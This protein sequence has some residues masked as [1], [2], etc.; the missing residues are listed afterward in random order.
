MVSQTHIAIAQD[1]QASHSMTWR[2]NLGRTNISLG[3]PRQSQWWT[4]LEPSSCPG[5]INGALTSLP[6][7][8]LDK[9]TRNQV[10]DYFNNTW[11]LT[12]VL[13]SSLIG[14]EAFYRPP[15]HSLRHPLVF[16]YG[17]PAVLYINK[18]LMAGLID[19]GIDARIER[20]FLTGVDEMSWDDMSKNDMLWPSIGEVWQYRKQVYK[21][22]SLVI[23]T[24]PD[25]DIDHA[26][27]DQGSPLWSL[28]MGFEHERIHL[29][30]SSVLIRELPLHLVS[31]PEAWPTSIVSSATTDSLVPLR[32]TDYPNNTMVHIPASI[33]SYG[34]PE[35]F[36]TYG[37]DNEYGARTAAVD[38]FLV[39]S[40]LIS[41]GEFC[42]F[43][44]DGGYLNRTYWSE[45]G[46][47]WRSF[48]D[49]QHPT[50]WRGNA[51]NG[52]RT[53]SELRTCFENIAMQWN[54]PAIVNFHEAKAFCQWKSLK[55]NRGY[56]LLTEAEHHAI[57]QAGK[58]FGS[59]TTNKSADA[60]YNANLRWGS[61]T[62]VNFAE[63]NNQDKVFDLF[64]NVWQWCED[65]FN[66]LAGSHVHP[67]YDDF[68]TPCYDGEH[69]MIMGGSFVS[70]GDEA[71][72]WARFHFRPHFFQH[73]GFRI[74]HSPSGSDGRVIHLSS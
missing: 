30:T 31:R 22:I 38:E 46:W 7:P 51:A 20:D 47:R 1:T 34:K 29:E 71:S 15:Y 26:P 53:N 56:R 67:Y 64:G 52:A 33:V 54:W 11:T 12:E 13:F 72:S 16:Y 14:D 18:F 61:E 68:S 59:D 6:L 17:H 48:R 40:Y 36:P 9:C 60:L 23:D 49:V 45:V 39:S 25:L 2:L 44:A 24:H 70:T 21:T 42:E 5:F 4:G 57:R 50:F 10:R 62:P 73:A 69:Q 66:P 27:I 19:R 55:D 28:F 63:S 3:I 8:E 74:V 37:W 58:Y 43:V 41:N 65:H 35:Q 32:S